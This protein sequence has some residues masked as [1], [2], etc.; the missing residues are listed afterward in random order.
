[1]TQH[2]T[3]AECKDEVAEKHGFENWCD[4]LIKFQGTDRVIIREQFDGMIDEAAEL[5]ASQFI[6]KDETISDKQIVD[7]IKLITDWPDVHDGPQN[8]TVNTAIKL[9][10]KFQSTQQ[11]AIE[12]LTDD[13]IKDLFKSKWTPGLF[14]VDK[15]N[16][17]KALQSK[18]KERV[19]CVDVEQL[20]KIRNEMYDSMP[21]GA[22][23]GVFDI[24]IAVNAHLTK[25]DNFIDNLTSKT[26][27]HER[28]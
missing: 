28:E 6:K 24:V 18:L 13:E 17:A 3:L 10:R 26:K 25:L 4:L 22:G 16:G 12:W 27:N 14:D 15:F 1:M 7:E 20:T 9:V 8:I 23:L 11:P 2:K 19:N 21:F 5:Y